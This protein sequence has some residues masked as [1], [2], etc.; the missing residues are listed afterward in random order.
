MSHSVRVVG[1]TSRVPASWQAPPVSTARRPAA[2]S[3]PGFDPE[4]HGGTI[5]LAESLGELEKGFQDGI[6]PTNYKDTL[7]PEEIKALTDYLVKV[8][9]K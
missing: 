3:K 5:V 8:A 1:T 2:T 6:M 9:S 7:Q 4:V